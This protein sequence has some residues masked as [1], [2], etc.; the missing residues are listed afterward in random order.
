ME[1][2]NHAI[3]DS[4]ALDRAHAVLRKAAVAGFLT[5]PPD[6]RGQRLWIARHAAGTFGLLGRLGAGARAA[7]AYV[8]GSRDEVL[9]SALFAAATARVVT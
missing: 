6:L 3:V 8:E 1:S 4:N 9:A 2:P 5:A 7:C